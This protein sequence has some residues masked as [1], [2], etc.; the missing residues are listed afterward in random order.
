MVFIGLRAVKI[1]PGN[2]S[3]GSWKNS[4][5]VHFN[6]HFIKYVHE[7]KMLLVMDD[8]SEYRIDDESLQVFLSACYGESN[9]RGDKLQ[10]QNKNAFD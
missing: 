10:E 9:I 3:S 7:K 2:P 1:E 5:V 8:N 6:P 4:S